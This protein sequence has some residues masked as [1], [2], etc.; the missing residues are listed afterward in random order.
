VTGSDI[1]AAKLKS[2]TLHTLHYSP[3]KLFVIKVERVKKM[4]GACNKH[5]E[6]INSYKILSIK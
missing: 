5:G 1:G 4:G 2:G 6:M 3:N